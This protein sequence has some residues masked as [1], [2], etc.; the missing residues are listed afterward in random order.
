MLEIAFFQNWIR[1]HMRTTS[2]EVALHWSQASECGGWEVCSDNQYRLGLQSDI[3]QLSGMSMILDVDG[4]I[5]LLLC[6][7]SPFRPEKVTVSMSDSRE[8]KKV[9]DCS[10]VISDELGLLSCIFGSV[11]RDSVCVYPLF[12]L[13]K[14]LGLT[15]RPVSKQSLCLHTHCPY[16]RFKG[17]IK[18]YPH[19]IYSSV[20][21]SVYSSV[22]TVSACVSS[23]FTQWQS[24]LTNCIINNVVHSWGQEDIC[25]TICTGT[26]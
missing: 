8:Q 1:L 4:R 14:L 5:G 11:W 10:N 26:T 9:L 7:L 23:S 25:T 2:I 16:F 24:V 18:Y 22:T 3:F 12:S 19:T 15:R 20:S 6:H 17:D 13:Q 21:S